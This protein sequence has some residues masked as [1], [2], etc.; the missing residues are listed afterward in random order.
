MEGR[1][2]NMGLDFKKNYRISSFLVTVLAVS[3]LGFAPSSAATTTTTAC[4]T[5]KTGAIRILLK[6]TCKAKIEKKISWKSKG[7]QGIQ[8]IQGI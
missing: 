6:G 4:V 1:L 8:G 2:M 3:L 5:T 7:L